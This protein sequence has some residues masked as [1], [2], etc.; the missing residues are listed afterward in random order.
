MTSRLLSSSPP[1][2]AVAAAPPM[3]A[4]TLPHAYL[5]LAYTKKASAKRR[6]AAAGGSGATTPPSPPPGDAVGAASAA[7]SA[8]RL[9]EHRVHVT[10]D[11]LTGLLVGMP[12]FGAPPAAA[13]GA[14]ADAPTAAARPSIFASLFRGGSRREGAAAASAA[15]GGAA[16]GGFT[17]SAPFNVQHKVHVSAAAGAPTGFAGMPPEWEE[18]L[19]T[20]GIS[21]AEVAAH[22]QAVLE[23]LQFTT[24]GPA[25][26]PR[27]NVSL[28][29]AHGAALATHLRADVDPHTL[30]ETL[31]GKLGEGASGVVLLGVEKAT[32]R[33]VAIKVA[34]A[35]DLANLKN[36]T[37]LLA[38]SQHP[39]IGALRA[40]RSDHTSPRKR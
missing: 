11:P 37:A 34:P 15:D 10:V 25:P 33:K 19:R 18:L 28:E 17:V 16:S 13:A 2:L 5:T 39:D 38:L 29:R 20:S 7:I 22:P 32:G 12:D 21:T 8:P 3:A 14:G 6:A 4:P 9:L 31:S 27:R 30:Y 23:V 26:K 35:T 24:Q 40:E 36:E 1:D